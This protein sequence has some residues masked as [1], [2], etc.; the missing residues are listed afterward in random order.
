MFDKIKALDVF[1]PMFQSLMY[2][3]VNYL[4]IVYCLFMC[5]CILLQALFFLLVFYIFLSCTVC[6]PMWAEHI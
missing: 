6:N 4:H 2:I 3:I 1:C 5:I